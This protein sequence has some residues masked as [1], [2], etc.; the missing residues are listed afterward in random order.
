MALVFA[1][2]RYIF[3]AITLPG[4]LN[5]RLELC[6]RQRLSEAN[7]ALLLIN[8]GLQKLVSLDNFEV[9][10]AQA[11]CLFGV[12]VRMIG[13]FWPGEDRRI[14]VMRAVIVRALHT[15]FV[16]ALEIQ[17][18]G[19]LRAIHLECHFA[20]GAKHSAADLQGSLHAVLEPYQRTDIILVGNGAGWPS[21]ADR[22][23]SPFTGSCQ[24]TFLDKRLLVGD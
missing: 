13:V 3:P 5:R 24:R 9:V 11:D 15:N 16:H 19:S 4:T 17:A 18:N 2:R 10:I 12:K 22:E 7:I 8:D 20:L 6:N 21:A 23:V 14:A 1:K